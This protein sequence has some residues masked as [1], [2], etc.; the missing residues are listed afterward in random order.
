MHKHSKETTKPPALARLMMKSYRR[1]W[2]THL[3]QRFTLFVKDLC[4][5]IGQLMTFNIPMLHMEGNSFEKFLK[6][7]PWENNK[8]LLLELD[9]NEKMTCQ[10]FPPLEKRE[11]VCVLLFLYGTHT[12]LPNISSVSAGQNRLHYHGSRDQT[13]PTSRPKLTRA[14]FIETDPNKAPLEYQQPSIV[15]LQ[16]LSDSRITSEVPESSPTAANNNKYD[17]TH[18]IR[19]RLLLVYWAFRWG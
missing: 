15:C 1:T 6:F 8:T 2:S 4:M 5:I 14:V 13:K 7:H 16:L 11:E 18:Q 9:H 17:K 12:C 3:D 10:D 19:S